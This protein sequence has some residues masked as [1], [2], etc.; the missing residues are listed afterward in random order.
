MKAIFLTLLLGA[1]A[2][3]AEP[4]TISLKN[5]KGESVGTATLRQMTKG[6]LVKLDLKNLTPGEHA[7]HF[8]EKGQCAGPKFESAGGHFNPGKNEHG[9]DMKNGPHEGDMPNVVAN[10][11]GSAMAEFVNTRVTLEKG[12][13]SLLKEGGTSLVIHEKADDFKSQPAGDAGGR[14]ACGTI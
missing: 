13:G 1:S 3:A 2:F 6:V 14:I 12:P 4:R 5:G 11:Q 8:H 10:Q 9:F 7:V